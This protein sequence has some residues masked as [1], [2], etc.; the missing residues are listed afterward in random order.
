[1]GERDFFHGIAQIWRKWT[2]VVGCSLCSEWEMPDPPVVNC[3]SPRRRREKESLL[4]LLSWSLLLVGDVLEERP[5]IESR[6]V[7]SPSRI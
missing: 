6:W 5:C 1:M 2:V 3:T 7:S 4:L